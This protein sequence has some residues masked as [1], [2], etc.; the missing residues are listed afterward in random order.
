MC[1]LGSFAGIHP[2][3]PPPTRLVEEKSDVAAWFSGRGKKVEEPATAPS[4]TGFWTH[5]KD[6]RMCGSRGGRHD[7]TK[8]KVRFK[9]NELMTTHY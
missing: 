3:H 9:S 7:E 2:P 1:H 4:L 8:T 6:S 5:P